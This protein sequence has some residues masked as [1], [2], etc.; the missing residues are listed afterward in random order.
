MTKNSQR[1]R[2]ACRMLGLLIPALTLFAS[3]AAAQQWPAKP[4][5]I[6]VPYTAGGPADLLVRAI[7]QKMDETWSQQVLVENR[8]GANEIIAAE[9]LAKS[10]A[11]GYTWLLA[12]DST[13]VLNPYLYTKIRYDPVRD[14]LPVSKLVTANMILVARP[15]FPANT[16]QELIDHVRKNSGNVTYGSVGAGGV[17]HLAMAWFATVHNLQMEHVSYKV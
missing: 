15:D 6:M 16:V 3:P 17:N 11:D 2:L 10:P 12:S 7:A 8:P 9:A 1:A 13:F 14:F 5:R 4:L